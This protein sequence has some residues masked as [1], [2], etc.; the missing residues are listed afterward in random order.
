MFIPFPLPCTGAK[1]VNKE[2]K[3]DSLGRRRLA[4][5]GKTTVSL[6]PPDK[7]APVLKKT[8]N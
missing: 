3:A 1:V 4:G 8:G 7:E 2:P 5:R 6:L